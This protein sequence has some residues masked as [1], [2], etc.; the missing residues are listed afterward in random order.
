MQDADFALHNLQIENNQIQEK[1][2]RLQDEYQ[3]LCN[4]QHELA[5]KRKQKILEKLNK[6]E[7]QM[8]NMKFLLTILEQE[9]HSAKVQYER[10]VLRFQQ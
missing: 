7:T 2:Q 10:E 3:N 1:Y 6:L 4:D 8:D 9:A 5:K